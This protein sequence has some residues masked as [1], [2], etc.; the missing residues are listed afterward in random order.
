MQYGHGALARQMRQV[1][2]I[3]INEE[4]TSLEDERN[5]GSLK[6]VNRSDRSRTLRDLGSA[7]GA[8]TSDVGFETAGLVLQRP[9]RL[10]TPERIF[11]ERRM[12]LP[13]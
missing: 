11:I 8:A 6:R 4:R 9:G 7:I 12:P 5:I 10:P 2:V 1:Q 13:R 3:H